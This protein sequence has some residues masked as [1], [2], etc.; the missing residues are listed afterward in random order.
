LKSVPRGKLDTSGDKGVGGFGVDIRAC[1]SLGAVL[2]SN[3]G[4]IRW[5]STLNN[6]AN[7]PVC[8]RLLRFI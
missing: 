5:A 7:K 1:L 4:I 2:T 3:S 8:L 6:H